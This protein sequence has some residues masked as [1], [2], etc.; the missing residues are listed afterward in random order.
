MNDFKKLKKLVKDNPKEITYKSY[1]IHKANCSLLLN[2]F[3]TKRNILDMYKLR[4][5]VEYIQTLYYHISKNDGS[6]E[7]LEVIKNDYSYFVKWVEEQSDF[8]IEKDIYGRN[9]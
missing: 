2:D 4:N 8:K 9:K 5:H 1:F 7:D 6:M 3:L